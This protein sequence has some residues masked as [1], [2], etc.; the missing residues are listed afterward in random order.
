[1]FLIKHFKCLFH[2]ILVAN[3]KHP[4][5]SSS[6]PPPF[7]VEADCGFCVMMVPGHIA[8]PLQLS[9]LFFILSPPLP[10]GT[11]H[12]LCFTPQACCLCKLSSL[13]LFIEIICFAHLEEVQF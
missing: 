7:P 3:A 11:E 9:P 1:M 4:Y 2:Q 13:M 12:A 5:D 6:S 8:A 10:P